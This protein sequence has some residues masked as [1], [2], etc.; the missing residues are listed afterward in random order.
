[1]T[2]KAGLHSPGRI[3]CLGDNCV[4]YYT[5]TGTAFFGGNPVNVAVYLQ[6]LGKRSSYLGAVGTDG[7]GRQMLAALSD[8]GV[9][10]SHVQICEGTTARTYVTLQGD[11]RVLGD[12]DEGVMR[13]FSLREK[14]YAF[15]GE[16]VLAVTGL[17]GHCEKCLEKIR[18]LGLTTAFDCADRPDDP[19]AQEAVPY[20]DLL[21]FSDGSRD[22]EAQREE[23]LRDKLQKLW[24]RG[25]K[26]ADGKP[27][28]H[29]VIATRG[30]RGSLAFDGE[31]FSS[32]GIIPCRVVDTMGAG[33]SYI[34][35]FLAA[36][37][38]GEPVSA[39]MKA[40]AVCSAGTLEHA[41]AWQTETGTDPD[42]G[43]TVNSTDR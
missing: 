31:T 20:T 33:D 16:H 34:A 2:D 3:A 15:I 1:M 35:G 29:I 13:D 17:W 14:D 21:F 27:A 4:D 42:P 36:Y 12:Y 6:K 9:D 30:S 43:V 7:Y 26:N 37:T 40:G 25:P 23:K 18:S 32:C 11:E 5:E 10:V 8:T 24:E 41:G 19:V 28:P 22:D 38:E 39:C